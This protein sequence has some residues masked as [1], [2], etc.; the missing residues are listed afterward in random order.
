MPWI[1]VASKLGSGRIEGWRN[2]IW[3]ERLHKPAKAWPSQRGNVL[4]WS[5]GRATGSHLLDW[6]WEAQNLIP[7]SRVKALQIASNPDNVLAT[8]GSQQSASL[9]DHLSP[10]SCTP[11]VQRPSSHDQVNLKSLNS[12]PGGPQSHCHGCRRI[13]VS[14]RYAYNGPF[15][16]QAHMACNGRIKID[17]SYSQRMV[18]QVF[19]SITLAYA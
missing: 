1:V 11:T 19:L 14:L 4:L 7:R 10:T 6:Y 5:S 18:C 13:V 12:W 2:P 9:S 15:C 17:I 16:D 3:K 8:V